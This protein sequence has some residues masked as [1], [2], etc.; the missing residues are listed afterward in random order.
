MGLGI[1]NM[2][3][4]GILKDVANKA[5]GHTAES[6]KNKKEDTWKCPN[7]KKLVSGAFCCYCGAKRMEAKCKHCGE[8][9]EENASFCSKCG[10]KIDE[11]K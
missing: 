5:F 7:C 11:D 8:K 2:T 9:I 6:A 1:V 3:S 10:N 4:D